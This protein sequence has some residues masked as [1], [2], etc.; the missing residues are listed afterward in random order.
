MVCLRPTAS[1]GFKLHSQKGGGNTLVL[2]V[3]KPPFFAKKAAFLTVCYRMAEE[4]AQV[5]ILTQVITML[6]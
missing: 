3:R 4:N 6:A 1:T 2:C 5:W